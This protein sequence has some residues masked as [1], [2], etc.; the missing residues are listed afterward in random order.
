MK[1]PKLKLVGRTDL[2]VSKATGKK[3]L[4]LGCTGW[5][6]TQTRL[7][8]G[9][10]LHIMLARDAAELFGIDLD[11]TGL[12]LLKNLGVKNLIRGDVYKLGEIV[13]PNDFDLIIAGELIEHLDKVGLFLESVK[14]VMSSHSELVITMPN[15]YSLKQLIHVLLGHDQQDPTHV[16]IYSYATISQLLAKHELY[17]KD[18]WMG[19]VVQTTTRSKVTTSVLAPVYRI[20]PQIA[21][22]IIVSVAKVRK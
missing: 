6:Q 16:A 21:D 17:I 19:T 5:P 3:V 11:E 8:D 13:L 1:L 9:S 20:F 12:E 18:I 10:H 22:N 2:L 4:H 15:A 14:A 7:D